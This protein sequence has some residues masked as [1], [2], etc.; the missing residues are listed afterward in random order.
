[1][2]LQFICAQGPTLR[3]AIKNKPLSSSNFL[4]EIREGVR[5]GWPNEVQ[6]II[7]LRPT[8]NELRN[9]RDVAATCY[10]FQ[11]WKRCRS[12]KRVHYIEI[13]KLRTQL[14]WAQSAYDKDLVVKLNA[15]CRRG[16][17]HDDI[18][19]RLTG[20]TADELGQ[21]WIKHLRDEQTTHP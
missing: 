17:Y 10:R 8:T 3:D 7:F 12:I 2:W 14:D 13:A 5:N 19:K 21:E 9:G 1:M 16:E 20:K 18:W 11:D 6:I 4:Y 15:A